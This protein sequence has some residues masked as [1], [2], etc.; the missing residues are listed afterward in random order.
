MKHNFY[1]LIY[2]QLPLAPPP[3]KSP[4]P[5][6]NPLNPESLPDDQLLPPPPP[7]KPPDV[8]PL[9]HVPEDH[10]P[11]PPK[12]LLMIEIIITRKINPGTNNKSK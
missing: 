10:L 5:P 11:P 8:Q 9:P 12:N 4:P 1:I 6:E 7:K 3:P 2:Y